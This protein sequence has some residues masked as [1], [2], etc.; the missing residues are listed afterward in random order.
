M[1]GTSMNAAKSSL[2]LLGIGIFLVI[3]LL[4][5]ASSF[6][7]PTNPTR[8][9]ETIDYPTPTPEINYVP[10]NAPIGY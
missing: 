6:L 3:A 9:A 10:N 4:L 1:I 5:F 7:G 8:P 2:I